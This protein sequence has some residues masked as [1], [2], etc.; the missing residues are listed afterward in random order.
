LAGVIVFAL[1]AGA[2]A[3][4]FVVTTAADTIADDGETSLREAIRFANVALGPDTITFSNGAGGSVNF[5]DATAETI[6][7]TLGE[8]DIC[9][10]LTITGPGA[11]KLSVSGGD[12]SRIFDIFEDDVTITG[13]T[14]RNG[15]AECGA[16][17]F[18][19]GGTLSMIGCVVKDSN[20][21][22][23]SGGGIY[24]EV[25]ALELTDT[26]VSG[27]SATEFGGGIVAVDR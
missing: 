13:L 25:G 21:T 23:D 2:G 15:L 19:D 10:A 18:N 26:T 6:T 4:G 22:I 20:A 5:H 27:N 14:L 24:V 3:A 7:L 17:V 12:A 16:A 11:E 8:I 9:G 1:A